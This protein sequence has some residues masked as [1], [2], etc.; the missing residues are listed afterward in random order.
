M[1]HEIRTSLPVEVRAA[2]DGT[3]K[4][5][6][7]AAVF[8]EE[9]DIGG[10]F[11]EVILPGA[12]TEA[13]SR[14]DVV[15]LVNHQGLPLARTKSGTLI[16]KQD[17]RGLYMESELDDSDPDVQTIV[18]KMKRGD[19]NKMSF[20]F[21]AMVQEWDDT[22]ETPLR[23]IQEAK[24]HDVSIVTTPAYDGTDI[25]LRSLQEHRDKASE[26]P[27]ISSNTHLRIQKKKAL[28]ESKA[29]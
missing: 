17:E 6:G 27:L 11:R 14:D 9:A 25:G 29:L 21:T 7:Y 19:L 8:N 22:E 23:S 28:I 5:S 1:P 20:A 16:L 26:S 13:I 15:F 10:Y 18:P 12:F 24:L 2:E 4:V 3:I